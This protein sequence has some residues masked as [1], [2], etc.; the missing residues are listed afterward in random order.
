MEAT[1]LCPKRTIRKYSKV[2]D[3]LEYSRTSLSL[4]LRDKYIGSTEKLVTRVFE[5]LST[6]ECPYLNESITFIQCAEYR[7]VMLP[8]KTQL[9]CGTG[10]NARAV[11]ELK[12]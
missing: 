3:E 6:V 5:V 11:R 4:A 1:C 10:V 2:A 9:K 12:A 8:H 7:S